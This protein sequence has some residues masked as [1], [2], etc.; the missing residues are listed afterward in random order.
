MAWVRFPDGSRRKVE[1][2]DKAQAERDLN[3][4]L[5]LRAEEASPGPRRLR[6]ATFDEVIDVRLVIGR[7]RVDRTRTERVEQVLQKMA[8]NGYAT[9]PPSC[10]PPGWVHEADRYLDGFWWVSNLPSARARALVHTPASYR[11]RGV[12][13]DRHDLAAA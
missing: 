6:L 13:L 4:L 2:V 11:R 3:E 10:P 5:A 9:S 7:L 12:M 8:D 1:R